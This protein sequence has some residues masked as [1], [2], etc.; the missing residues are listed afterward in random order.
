VRQ[1]VDVDALLTRAE[2]GLALL[3]SVHAARPGS[4][5]L[6]AVR[7]DVET[8]IRRVQALCSRNP[9]WCRRYRRVVGWCGRGCCCRRR[10][11]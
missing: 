7:D 11:H 5:A 8:T 3:P 2:L 6:R 10:R 4:P 9:P 1:V